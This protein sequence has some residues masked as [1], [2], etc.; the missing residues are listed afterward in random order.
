MGKKILFVAGVYGVGKTTLCNALSSRYNVSS[1]SASELIS[2][3][4]HEIYGKNKYVK[5]SK[6]NQEILVN[7]VSKIND[8]SFILNGH[9]CLKA[10]NNKVILL[11]NEVFNKLNL[12]CI[13]LLIAPVDVIKENLF[14]RDKVYYDKEYIEFLLKSEEK[15]AEKVSDLYN[16]PLLKYSMEF[17]SNDIEN[18]I[19]LLKKLEDKQ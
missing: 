10:K 8:E 11:E 16:I 4:N 19:E 2:A 13:L 15:Q 14:K 18:I 17:K 9:F 7:Q 6:Y 12:S 1:Y 3:C 5:D